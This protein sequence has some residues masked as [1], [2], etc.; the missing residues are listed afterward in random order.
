M[1]RATTAPAGPTAARSGGSAR[2]VPQPTSTATPPAPDARLGDRRAVRGQVVAELGV[3][4]RGAAGEERAGL[5]QV[6]GP[7]AASGAATRLITGQRIVV[8]VDDHVARSSRFSRSSRSSRFAGLLRSSRASSTLRFSPSS[9]TSGSLRYTGEC[10][11]AIR[12]EDGNV[13]VLACL[14]VRD[15]ARSTRS[16]SPGPPPPGGASPRS[17]ASGSRAS[18]WNS[19]ASPPPSSSTTPT[20]RPPRPRSRRPSACCPARSAR[21]SPGSWSPG[22]GTTRCSRP[23]PPRSPQVKVGDPY[24]PAT[25]MGPLA[26]ERQRDRVEG[27]IATG[28][29]G[30]ATLATGGG[31]PRT[32]T[33][34]GTSSRP[35]S[36]TWTTPR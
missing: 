9:R 4:G 36:A 8:Q 26:A 16:P 30:G 23:S 34:A 2:P 10:L 12:P 5:G 33:A 13:P 19:A 6:P 7:R 31:R 15:P 28:I 22:R 14:L 35:C 25:Q 27:Y 11:P 29:A 17:A 18:P 21:P 3:P 24:D 20:S 32:S 1:S